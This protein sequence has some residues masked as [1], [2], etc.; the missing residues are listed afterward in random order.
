MPNRS[1]HRVASRMAHIAPFQVMS[2][3]ARARSLEAA[4]HDVIHME[5]GE[6]DFPTP[7]PII[8]A[9]I[10]ALEQGHTRYTTATGLIQLRE[11]IAQHYRQRFDTLIDP[12][13]ILITPGASG[14]LL[15]VL[16]LLID[17]DDEVLLAD[18]TYP[19]NR[20]LISLFEGRPHSIPVGPEHNFQPTPS[21]IESEWREHTRALMLATPANPTGTVI[22]RTTMNN[23]QATVTARGGH[24]IVDEI[25]QGLIYGH[26]D[27]T[28]L[29]ISP[30][31]FV[32]N[33]FSKY[34]NMT[35]W[36]LGWLVIPKAFTTEAEKLAMNMF[37]AAPTPAQ[38]AALAAFLPETQAI[39]QQYRTELEQRR[40][41][42]LAELPR[43][44]FSIPA[45][46]GGAFYVYADC[47]MLTA[48]SWRFCHE[49]LEQ[50]HVATTPGADFGQHQA[51]R[52]I[53]FAYTAT[54]PRLKQ[55]LERIARFVQW[56]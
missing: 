2:L 19:C 25:Y 14:A 4:G 13:R 35:G 46:P 43:C 24:L 36:R 22:D 3:L 31:N 5:I 23:L 37:L 28:A 9:G 48:D 41:Y 53:R 32:I 45:Q 18:P 50:A 56:Q 29:D 40:N 17:R 44:G 33:S 39:Q 26:E 12:E 15:L 55:A 38:Y 30:D 16:G 6:P 51:H 21:Q 47:S 8:Q 52:Y 49:L 42:L 7:Q 34:F 54:V 11:A 1:S 27:Y 10:R 20:H